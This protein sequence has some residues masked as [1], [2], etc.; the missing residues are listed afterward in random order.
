MELVDILRC[1]IAILGM[2]SLSFAEPENRSP[3]L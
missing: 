1:S 2:L 3:F